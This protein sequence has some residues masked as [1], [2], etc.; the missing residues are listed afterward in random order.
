MKKTAP[1][2]IPEAAPTTTVSCPQCGATVVWTS[3]SRWKPFCSERCKLLDLGAWA[4]ESYRVA[5]AETADTSEMESA[6]AASLTGVP[7]HH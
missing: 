3:A 1:E 5:S 7:R 6:L 4:N 2:T